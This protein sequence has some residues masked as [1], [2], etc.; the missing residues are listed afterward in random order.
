MLKLRDGETSIP[1]LCEKMRVVCVRASLLPDRP[2]RVQDAHEAD[3]ALLRAACVIAIVRSTAE[4]AAQGNALQE[5]AEARR[6][7][8]TRQITPMI[9]NEINELPRK[10][11]PG[12]AR[13]CVRVLEYS[14]E[15]E[16]VLEYAHILEYRYVHKGGHSAV[17][18]GNFGVQVPVPGYDARP[19]LGR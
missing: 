2:S 19:S 14:Y 15:L 4:C 8:H 6:R 18:R 7:K 9:H 10:A 5:S 3:G 16:D 1:A 13:M 12:R 11:P 17:G